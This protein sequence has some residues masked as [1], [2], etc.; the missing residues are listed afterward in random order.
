MRAVTDRRVAV[1]AVRR[2]GRVERGERLIARAAR[3]AAHEVVGRDGEVPRQRELGAREAGGIERVERLDEA[4]ARGLEQR[5]RALNLF[6]TDIYGPGNIL[7]AGVIPADLVY[8]NPCFRPEMTG[9]KLPHDLYVHIAGIDIIRTDADDFYVLEDNARTP[10]GVSYMLENREATMRIFPDLFADHRI[11]PV[12]NYPEE[13]LATL[14]SAAPAS[15][16]ADPI[17][18]LLTPGPLNS[19]YYEHSFL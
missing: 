10:S 15:A 5:V 6:L 3:R 16:P 9:L 7:K 11:D 14:E 12:E 1:D 4:R 13:L 2:R 17:V 18:V 8:R 19:A